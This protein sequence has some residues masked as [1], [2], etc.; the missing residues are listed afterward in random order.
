MQPLI[1]CPNGTT[2]NGCG[3]RFTGQLWPWVLIHLSGLNSWLSSISSLW[4]VHAN[5]IVTIVPD[6]TSYPDKT[7]SDFVFRDRY[8]KSG[9]NLLFSFRQARV[10][11]SFWSCSLSK[12]VSSPPM[13]FLTS[14]H[15][16]SW[17]S[18][19][20]DISNK[21]YVAVSVIVLREALSISRHA[22][23]FSISERSEFWSITFSSQRSIS[24][25]IPSYWRFSF[26]SYCFHKCVSVDF[27]LEKRVSRSINVG[28]KFSIPLANFLTD[29]SWIS[30]L[31]KHPK[32][33]PNKVIPAHSNTH[34][35][36]CC[37]ISWISSFPGSFCFSKYSIK[38]YV[39]LL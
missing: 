27:S 35:K 11:G 1:P 33:S 4:L 19:H 36:I 21:A 14:W 13:L 9:C 3:L 18:G 15:I 34:Q 32:R 30:L 31:S 24:S 2:A 5:N 26:C 6:G 16:F 7:R 17:T 29:V 39:A 20:F 38:S 8:G 25:A 22:V 37:L 10:Y 28:I 12:I 23:T